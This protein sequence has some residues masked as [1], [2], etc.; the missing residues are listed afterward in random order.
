MNR[1]SPW[2]APLAYAAIC[3]ATTVSMRPVMAAD[4]QDTVL[5]PAVRSWMGILTLVAEDG[6]REKERGGRDGRGRREG[7]ERGRG[8]GA[9]SMPPMAEPMPRMDH[10]PMPMMPPPQGPRPDAVV[11]L[12]EILARLGRIEAMLAGS[13]PGGRGPEAGQREPQTGPRRS[14][15]GPGRPEF[16]RP[17][18]NVPPAAREQMGALGKEARERWEKMTPEER[19]EMRKKMEA[20]RE[21]MREG[22]RRWLPDGEARGERPRSPGQ[23]GT[24]AEGER[25]AQPD[26]DRVQAVMR[27]ARERFAVME[28]RIKAL[29]AEVKRLKQEM[30]EDDD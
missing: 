25:S 23:E 29:E 4:W 26:V 12:D 1:C 6:G 9:P 3:V 13:R 2:L 17:G 19:A 24:R 16:R 22:G 20:A 10:P 7:G 14:E 8:R 18:D 15:A 5:N 21:R 30:D 11:K 27:A 28:Q